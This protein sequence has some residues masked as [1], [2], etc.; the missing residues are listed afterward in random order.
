MRLTLIT[1]NYNGAESTIKLLESLKNQ[2]DSDFSIIVADNASHD[3]QK[4]R[5]YNASKSI[6]IIENGAN[7]GYAVGNNP[8]LRHAFNS[9]ADWALIINND[10]WVESDFIAR[11]KANLNSKKGIVGLPLNEGGEITYAGKLDWL[12]PKLRHFSL[13]PRDTIDR[14]RAWNSSYRILL[15]QS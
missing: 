15:E 14:R 11:L 13:A 7:L 3:I 10:T 12:K 8:A 4:I 5:D 6:H 2:T 9:G 1:L